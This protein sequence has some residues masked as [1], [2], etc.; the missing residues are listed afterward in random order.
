MLYMPASNARA[1]EKAA[2][3]DTDAIA[4]DLEDS[5]D[6][7]VKVRAREAACAAIKS[8]PYGDRFVVLRLNGFDT[9]WHTDDLNAACYAKP[10]A[11]LLPKVESGDQIKTLASKLAE[12][13]GEQ[14]AVWAMIETPRG[15]THANDIAAAC[16]DHSSN[17]A[18]CLGN[19]DLTIAAG[20]E[21]GADRCWLVPWMMSLLLACKTHHVHCFDGVFNNFSDQSGFESECIQGAAMG[22][23]GKTLIHPKQIEITNQVFSPSA[24]TIES[25]QKIVEAFKQ[26]ENQARSAI[27]IDGAM[28]E[29]LHLH[30]AERILLTAQQRTDRST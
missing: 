9:Q 10:D 13:G 19:N 14:I 23:D 27:Q 6:P 15:I 29:R 24:Q 28:V 21:Q 26:P 4:I 8:K 3:L 17:A 30:W 20:M 18:C 12:H 2:T 16:A 5:V 1:L 11:V 25:A 7:T 22:F